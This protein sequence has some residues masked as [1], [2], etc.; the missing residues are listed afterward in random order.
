V[1]EWG[2]F[3]REPLV[4]FLAIGIGCFAVFAIVHDSQP[5]GTD[6]RIVVTDSDAEWLS[7]DFA[8]LWNWSSFY[9]HTG[10]LRLRSS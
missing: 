7:Q 2:S 5:A 10:R 3:L 9:R 1:S 8:R 6:T 4:H